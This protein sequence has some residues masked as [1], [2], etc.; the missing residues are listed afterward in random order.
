M[1]SAFSWQNSSRYRNRLF[2]I[3]DTAFHQ[4]AEYQYIGCVY[5]AVRSSELS[6]MYG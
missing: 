2:K 4:M 1:T 3:F 6:I 5:R